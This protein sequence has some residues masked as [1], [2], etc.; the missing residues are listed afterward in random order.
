M[1]A[2]NCDLPVDEKG[3]KYQVH[4]INGIK[5]DNRIDNLICLSVDEH[6]KLHQIGKYNT[7]K[8]KPILQID[9]DTNEIIAEFPSGAEVE[10]IL[11]FN[12]S[13]INNVCK[14]KRKTA[15]GFI[16]KYK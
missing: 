12:V 1:C 7:K 13:N 6:N 8:S 16:W 15:Y 5:D 3:R 9:K 10:R 4:H 11:G 2:N 14:G